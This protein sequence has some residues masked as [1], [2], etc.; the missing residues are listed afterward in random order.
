VLNER[1]RALAAAGIE[2]VVIWPFP[3]AGQETEDLMLR[4]AKD[5]LPHVGGRVER[6]A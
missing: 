6:I 4:L 5:V 1:L 3:A 2:E